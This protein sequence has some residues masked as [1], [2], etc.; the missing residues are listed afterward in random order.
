MSPP[1]KKNKLGGAAVLLVGGLAGVDPVTVDVHGLRQV[2]DG[3]LELLQAHGA[4][5]DARVAGTVHLDVA[6]LLVVAEGAGELRLQRP[7]HLLLGG[8]LPLRLAAAHGWPRRSG[9]APPWIPAL[10]VLLPEPLQFSNS[11]IQLYFAELYLF[12]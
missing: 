3:G 4:R 2:G 9:R 1:Q 6:G 7:R 11:I 10:L 12:I 8:G 5:D